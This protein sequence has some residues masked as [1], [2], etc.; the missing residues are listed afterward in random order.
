MT[1]LILLAMATVLF[2]WAGWTLRLVMSRAEVCA[3][4]EAERLVGAALIDTLRRQVADAL[5][6]ETAAVALIQELLT[7]LGAVLPYAESRVEDM[8]AE[9]ADCDEPA[10]RLLF[11]AKWLDESK[12]LSAAARAKFDHAHEVKRRAEARP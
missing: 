10:M 6:S 12:A 11:D 7:E 8:E 3:E 5:V 9:A 2:V 1:T 4:L